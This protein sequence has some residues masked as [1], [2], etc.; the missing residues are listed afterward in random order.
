MSNQVTLVQLERD[1]RWQGDQLRA[2]LRHTPADI[3]RVITQSAREYREMISDGG[4]PYYLKQFGG[5]LPTGRA[6]NPND[7][8]IVHQWTEINTSVLHPPLVR[9]YGLD[10]HTGQY[11]YRLDQ[12]SFN[13]RMNYQFDNE[14]GDPTAWFGYGGDTVCVVPPV[15]TPF[16]FT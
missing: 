13:D 2:Q 12:V 8:S 1:V 4:H 11:S 9:I 7:E 10:V 16:K 6:H 3:R 14:I 5:I 15:T